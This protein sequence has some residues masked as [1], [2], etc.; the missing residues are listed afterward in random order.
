M[1]TTTK[2]SIEEVAAE[3]GL[4]MKADFVPLSKS[5][6]AGEKY[7]TLNWK[8]TIQKGGRSIIETDYS[9]GIAHCPAY[10]ASVKQLGH[11]NSVMRDGY[12]RRECETGHRALLV[13]GSVGQSM[14]MPIMP[15]FASVLHS[16]V[17]DA[18]AIDYSRFEDWASDY[19]YDT[20]SRKGEATYRTCLEFG[21][22][23]RNALGEDGLATLRSA[24]QDY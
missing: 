10:N 11:K 15:E 2:E 7:P 21:L 16:L 14:G 1:T 13:V 4:T 24:V 19:G 3:L 20:D 5:R 8:V 18:G 9:A 17:S 22:K 23:L 6:N 12:I